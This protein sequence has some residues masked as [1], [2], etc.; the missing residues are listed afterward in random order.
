M[1]REIYTRLLRF[2]KDGQNAVLVTRFT[3]D[4]GLQKDMEKAVIAGIPFEGVPAQVL[5]QGIPITFTENDSTVLMEPYYPEERLIILGGGHIALPLTDF[6]ARI[7]FSVIVVDDR[8]SFANSARFPAAS[9]VICSGF[10]EAIEKLRITAGDYVVII[11]RGHR[12]DR[13]CLTQ[14][15]NGIEPFYTGM[16]GSRRRVAIVKDELSASGYDS[17]K[18]KRV[19]SPIG[20]TIGAVTPEEIAVSITAELIS[21][22]RINND[23]SREANRNSNRSDIDM[24]VL[25]A[26]SDEV[27]EPKSI[28][29]II[30]SKGSVP[31]G[32]GAKMLVY[33]Y[34]KITGSIGGGCSEGAVIND[35]R[36]II[37]TG[38]YLVKTVDMTGEAAEDEGMVCGGIMQVLI[39]DY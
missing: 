3:Q 10:E 1:D 7:G 32:P 15:L 22:K 24:D 4:H 16:I 5:A 14:L 17:V 28:V 26:L 2:L 25:R 6:A 29:T 34:G 8:P 23:P 18:L 37:G 38:G 33:P 39:E 21:C 31:R 12:H 27:D 20:L 35:A 19:H 13:D 11:T 36:R 30:S 9:K